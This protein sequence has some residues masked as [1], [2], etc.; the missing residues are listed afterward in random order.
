MRC[1]RV[2]SSPGWSGPSGAA[3][4]TA[5]PAGS[6]PDL[7]EPHLGIAVD[8]FLTFL[9]VEP[10]LW[11]SK[12]TMTRDSIAALSSPLE[13]RELLV[14]DRAMLWWMSMR[15]SNGPLMRAR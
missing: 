4:G 6:A 7:L 11:R 9:T 15:S 1:R 8:P 2:G 13:E 10:R 12:A 3:P 14:G 5:H